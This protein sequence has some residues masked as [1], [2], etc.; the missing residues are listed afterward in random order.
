MEKTATEYR[1]SIS[2]GSGLTTNLYRIVT[3]R[4]TG[5]Q[6]YEMAIG[7]GK[8]TIFD[9]ADLETLLQYR[10]FAS[11]GKY[12]WYACM[13]VEGRVGRLHM[14]LT[15]WKY[16]HHVDGDSLNNRRSNL[17]ESNALSNNRDRLA[18]PRSNT[19]IT[20]VTLLRAMKCGKVFYTYRAYIS[21]ED[22]TDTHRADFSVTKLG[23]AEALRQAVEW[24]KM[25]EKTFG[26]VLKESTKR[27]RG[28]DDLDLPPAKHP[29]FA[30]DWQDH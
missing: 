11:K 23:K 17:K 5:A 22:N 8:T 20:G 2:L 10:V 26:Y 13:G 24:R 4:S 15:G 30:L 1:D 21:A 16:V 18:R 19:G 7:H 27:K 12:K 29:R 14:H 28:P 6:W 9:L 25:R 3:E